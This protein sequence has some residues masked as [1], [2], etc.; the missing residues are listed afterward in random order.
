MERVSVRAGEGTSTG[1]PSIHGP[2]G[3]ILRPSAFGLRASA[4]INLLLLATVLPLPAQ[5]ASAPPRDPFMSLMVSQPQIHI[6]DAPQATAS[7]DPPVVRPGE[8][9][10]Y[11]VVFN[12]LEESIE[13]PAKLT[14]PPQLET[15]P[16]AHGQFLQSTGTSLE[17][18][19][20]FNYRVRASRLGP[21]TMPEFV[22]QVYGKAVTVPAAQLLVVS[23]PPAGVRATPMAGLEIPVTN[24]VVGQAVSMR[25]VLPGLPPGFG[26]GLG[27]PQ[28]SGQGVLVDL[29]AARVRIESL[30]RGGSYGP[31]FTYETT[32]TPVT[33]GK[34][35]VFAQGFTSGSRSSGPV[36]INGGMTVPGF[37][38]Q[39]TLLESEP[40]ELNV[41][42][43]PTEGA[44]PGFTGAIGSFAVGPPRLTT[45][46]LRVGDLVK[47]VAHE[48]PARRGPHQT[49]RHGH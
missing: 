18:H 20:S 22:V 28:L 36:V 5:P 8:R 49:H 47:Q 16:G 34:L 29:G 2:G 26:Q 46:V 17:P 38:A 40:V 6:S 3:V 32:L 10:F 25:I 42:P 48:R 24:L 12:A 44:L 39:F 31:S 27:G 37:P 35:Q 15:R 11:R 45:N 43:L 30:P 21:C 7:F 13:W 9:A 4:L 1:S 14:A 19:T 33:T 23:E 41:R